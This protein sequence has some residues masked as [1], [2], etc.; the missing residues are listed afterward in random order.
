MCRHAQCGLHTTTNV[1]ALP[2]LNAKCTV[3]FTPASNGSKVTTKC[4]TSDFTLDEIKTLCAMMDASNPAATTTAEFL[5]GTP[6]YRTDLYARKCSRVLTL[7][8]FIKIVD[9][10]GLKFTAELK[11]P[12]VPIRFPVGNDYTQAKYAQHLIDEFKE[13]GI[14]P[15]RVW[16]QSFLYDDLLY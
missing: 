12:E 3:P 10:L 11:T 4:C 1:V 13:A 6:G 7:R 16:L 2:E 5:S 8:E 14:K 9:D 15:G